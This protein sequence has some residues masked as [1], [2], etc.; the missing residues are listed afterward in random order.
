MFGLSIFVI[1]GTFFFQDK[2]SQFRA[3]GLLGIFI[4]NFF[5]S[6]TIFLPAPG[7]A[8]VV[9]GGAL[10]NPI[11]VGI[12]AGLGAALGDMVGFILG[13]SGKEVFL[14]KKE[15]F[16]YAVFKD[17]FLHY[18]TWVIFIFAFIPNPLFD[19]IGIIA[20]AFSYPP[21]KF[22]IVM[23]ISRVLRNL[24]LASIGAKI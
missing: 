22:F 1:F 23:L 14:K 21:K 15:G 3:L 7:I 16:K 5:S 11:L 17:L 4:L 13:K 10:Y 6:V 2:L 9:A 20:G 24:V 18:G 19:A 12:F 8:T